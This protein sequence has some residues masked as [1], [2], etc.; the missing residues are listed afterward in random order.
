[1][2]YYPGNEVKLPGFHRTAA[3][4]VRSISRVRFCSDARKWSASPPHVGR[5]RAGLFA[6]E[7]LI[8]WKSL[9]KFPL[10][11]HGGGIIAAP[12]ANGMPG[13]S[14]Y[15]KSKTKSGKQEEVRTHRHE[16]KG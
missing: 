16:R 4:R 6:S 1:M 13:R 9:R 15:E 3:E 5:R 14:P 2:V 11:P 7:R 10:F 8:F 12:A